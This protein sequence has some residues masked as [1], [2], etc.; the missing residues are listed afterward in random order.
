MTVVAFCCGLSAQTELQLREDHIT[1]IV[2][3]RPT[4]TLDSVKCNADGDLFVRFF[5][6][7]LLVEPIT[8]IKLSGA[9]D[10]LFSIGSDPENRNASMVDFS[11]TEAG[12]L[13]ALILGPPGVKIVRFSKDGRFDSS[14]PVDLGFA[15][16]LTQ[17][18]SLPG[19]N[20]FLSGTVTTKSEGRE[21]GDPVNLIV[22][23]QGRVLRDLRLPKDER[24]DQKANAK[25]AH[26][27]AN[28]AVAHGRALLGEDG[29]IY[30]MRSVSPALFFVVSPAGTL[31][32][33]FGISAPIP[34]SVPRMF[35]V[36]KGRMA[37]EFYRGAEGKQ[38]QKIVY[39]VVNA[40]DGRYV[41]D[42]S[43]LPGRGGWAC[44]SGDDFTFLGAENEQE[45][46]VTTSP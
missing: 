7:A 35:A 30:I 41:A 45:V 29:N 34:K 39:R 42:Y 23:A 33:K 9:T 38:P 21:S 22:D 26:D 14:I 13:D 25:D 10:A 28:P 18:V 40:G 15:A 2:G 16:D 43:T 24:P 6:I 5:H 1:P 32:R 36:A 20:F 37:V 3:M 27:E 8:K 4:P 44:F 12:G 31:V 17:L 46:I 19:G 11:P